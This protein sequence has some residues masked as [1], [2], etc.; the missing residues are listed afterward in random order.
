MATPT[1]A[2]AGGA[3]E[4]A[5]RHGEQPGVR[6]EPAAPG[7]RLRLHGRHPHPAAAGASAGGRAR[8]RQG[9]DRQAQL[10]SGGRGGGHGAPLVARLPSP[11][12]LGRRQPRAARWQQQV[13]RGKSGNFGGGRCRGACGLLVVVIGGVRRRRVELNGL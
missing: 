1:S 8:H 13:G 6:G 7:P 11:R 9:R 4:P 5:R 10:P 3:R 12:G 2:A